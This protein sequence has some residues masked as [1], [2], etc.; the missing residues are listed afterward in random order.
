MLF[1][2]DRRPE[3]YLR[4]LQV[5]VGQ[6]IRPDYVDIKRRRDSEDGVKNL[7]YLRG[8]SDVVCWIKSV[9][10]KFITCWFL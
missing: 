6:K 3:N 9:G 4:C 7:V 1:F 2:R 5:F 10:N 8:L